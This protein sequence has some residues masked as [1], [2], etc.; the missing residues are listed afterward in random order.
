[1]AGL[2]PEPVSGA[3]AR[4][5]GVTTLT[6]NQ[7]MGDA[8]TVF[9]LHGTGWTPGERLTV[10]IGGTTSPH[11]PPVDDR[12][13]FNYAVNQADEFWPAQLPVGRHT[14]TVTGASATRTVHFAVHP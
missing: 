7:P 6:V 3:N 5:D 14:A 4:P 1:P 10:T 2:P 9:V 12:G 11:R 8:R 13:T